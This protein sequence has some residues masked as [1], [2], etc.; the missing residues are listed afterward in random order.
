MITIDDGFKSFY[1]EAWPYLKENK[2]PFI[3]FVSTEPVGKKG[4]MTW[5]EIK[6]IDQSKIGYIGHH[7]HTHEYLIDMENDEF[8]NDINKASKIFKKKLG[9]IPDIFSYPFGEYSK[10]MKKYFKKF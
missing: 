7:S 4:Y 5:D 3:L 10:Y 8:I 1:D 9:Y 6:E 2:I